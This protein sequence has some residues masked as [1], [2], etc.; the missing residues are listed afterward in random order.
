MEFKS[1]LVAENIIVEVIINMIA[2]G[3]SLTLNN[4]KILNVSA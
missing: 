1:A 3:R 2:V 4:D